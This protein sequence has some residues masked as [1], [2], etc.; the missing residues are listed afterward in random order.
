MCI[1]HFNKGVY[2]CYREIFNG[3]LVHS[4]MLLGMFQ[5]IVCILSILMKEFYSCFREILRMLVGIFKL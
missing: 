3:S 5:I 2:F 1:V 4:C